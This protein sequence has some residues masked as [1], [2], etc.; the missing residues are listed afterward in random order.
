MFPIVIAAAWWAGYELVAALAGNQW[1]ILV[2]VASGFPIG[3]AYQSLLA[4]AVQ[5]YV[6]W[7]MVNLVIVCG[8]TVVVASLLHAWNVK[9]RLSP[10][11]SLKRIDIGAMTVA[12]AIM[13]LFLRVIY[14][15]H[16]IYTR[17]AAWSDFA[18]HSAMITSMAYGFNVNRT[19]MFGFE[20]GILA[21]SELSYPVLVNFHAAF[22]MAD[23]GISLQNAMKWTALIIGV[24]VVVLIHSLTLR[25]TGGDSCAAALS[26]PLWAFTGGIGFLEVLD[27]GINVRKLHTNY[28]H[29]FD[30]RNNVFWF[31][32]LTHVF[33]PQ[34]SA[35]F[36]I[37]LCFVALHA[38]LMGVEAFEYRFFLLAAICVGIMPQV[39][40][41]A[42]V[43]VAIFSVVL[44]VT[45]CTF[46]ERMINMIVCWVIY[47]VVANV[48]GL[49]LCLPF[50]TRAGGSDKF[51][52]W[53]PIWQNEEFVK[54]ASSCPFIEIWWYAL[55]V[56]GIIA[57]V[58]GFATSTF[59]Q[60]RLYVPALSIA[61][62]GSTIMFQPWELDN[63]KLFM[64]AWIPLAVGF[65]AQYF[66]RLWTTTASA[67]FRGILSVLYVSCLMSGLLSVIL[68]EHAK[69]PLC[70]PTDVCV[71]NWISEN[72]N[73]H[74]IFHGPDNPHNPA[75][76]LG[77]RRLFYGY[78]GWM[79]SHDLINM[80]RA[81]IMMTDV[82][83]LLLDEIHNNEIKYYV[84]Y[85][86]KNVTGTHLNEPSSEGWTKVFTSTRYHVWS[87]TWTPSPT[88]TK[89]TNRQ[90]RRPRQRAM[91]IV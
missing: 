37:P 87:F 47:G 84:E 58:F 52:T 18:F 86:D 23:C 33:H 56:F 57:F 51:I 70:H 46:G 75:L 59:E 41:H 48:I 2:R 20:V 88:T 43:S 22:L 8:S 54:L 25:F 29:Q 4:L 83:D 34:R 24:C 64:D 35:T 85:E 60:A 19:S 72:T 39:Q 65:V 44:A 73:P 53:K 12:S 68:M 32:S 14:F 82:S 80:T 13:V 55:G 49:P 28:I 36:A 31:Q 26:L 38:L 50:F 79:V 1:N 91:Q 9:K 61:V 6:P 78:G 74:A 76:M 7:G 89:S 42:Y 62:V 21:G 77:G 27:N 10:R 90:S 11:V 40:V 71:S 17:G 69:G 45:T 15:E 16:G 66:S 81:R 3:F 5:L 67:V 30:S 63:C